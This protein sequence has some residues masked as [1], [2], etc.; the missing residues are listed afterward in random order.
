MTVAGVV[1][2]ENGLDDFM[3]LLGR[4]MK[5]KTSGV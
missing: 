4:G 2:V 1:V 3:G 5:E